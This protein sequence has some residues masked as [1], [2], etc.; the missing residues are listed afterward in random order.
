MSTYLRVH[1]SVAQSGQAEKSE[2]PHG[3]IVMAHGP[4]GTALQ[5][6]HVDGLWYAPKSRRAGMTWVQVLEWSSHPVMIIYTAP[7]ED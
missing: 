2:P 7:Q 4:T 1:K 6:L 3:S 5:R